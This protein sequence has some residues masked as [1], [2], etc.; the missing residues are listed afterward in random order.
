M[1]CGEATVI[2]RSYKTGDPV[3]FIVSKVST[4][5]GR[6]AAGVRPAPH[7]DTYNYTV[8]KYWLVVGRSLAGQLLLATRRGKIHLVDE[9][10]FRLRPA[11]W[12]ERLLLAE[13]FPKLDHLQRTG[14]L[15]ADAI[16]N[17]QLASNSISSGSISSGTLGGT[18]SQNS[19]QNRLDSPLG[20]QRGQL[21]L[22]T[23]PD[24]AKELSVR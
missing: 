1:S 16:A 5:P 11:R 7:G 21:R 4:E 10:D 3:V 6:R 24:A 15:S 17:A 13:R 12:W 20:G 9:K 8:R 14:A 2:W 22:T 18:A 19:G 23:T